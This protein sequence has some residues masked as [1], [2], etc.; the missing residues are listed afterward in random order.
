MKKRAFVLL[1]S[2]LSGL[3][4]RAAELDKNPDDNAES[5]LECVD[6]GAEAE[7]RDLVRAILLKFKSSAA[8]RMASQ[9]PSERYLDGLPDV[10]KADVERQF[11]ELRAFLQ[12]C[13]LAGKSLHKRDE[14]CDIACRRIVVTLEAAVARSQIPELLRENKVS[15]VH[16][17]LRRRAPRPD[18]EVRAIL[19]YVERRTACEEGDEEEE[20]R[21]SLGE[22]FTELVGGL[23]ER[24]P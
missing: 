5:E 14:R 24:L 13:D 12:A 7:S 8:T 23:R 15:G 2:L 6:S 21:L 4:L 11:P 1:L 9:I 22:R 18:H 3:L 20:A 17:A 16:V 10:L 19:K